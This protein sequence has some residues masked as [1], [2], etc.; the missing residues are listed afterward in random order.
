MAEVGCFFFSLLESWGCY[1]AILFLAQSDEY[2]P[3]CGKIPLTA[4]LVQRTFIV[5]ALFGHRMWLLQLWSHREGWMMLSA[6]LLCKPSPIFCHSSSLVL[7]SQSLLTVCHFSAACFDSSG[8]SAELGPWS[9]A[10]HCS[11]IR[12][13]DKTVLQIQV[14]PCSSK[15]LGWPVK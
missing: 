8:F 1:N 14:H 6:M 7:T 4:V 2:D 12:V 9:A 13:L 10:A 11:P 3:Y 5:D 15:S